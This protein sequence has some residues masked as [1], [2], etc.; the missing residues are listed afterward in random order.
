[1]GHQVYDREPH[2][3]LG[4]DTRILDSGLEIPPPL[5]EA[6]TL[7][8]SWSFLLFTIFGG[9]VPSYVKRWFGFQTPDVTEGTW[10]GELIQYDPR[11]FQT[12]L[13][14]LT[15]SKSR[16]DTVLKVCREKGGARFT[17]L[18]NQLIVHSL[19]GALAVHGSSQRSVDN[20]I[21][22][23][24]ID[25]RGLVVAYSDDM[26]VNCVS[27]AYEASSFHQGNTEKGL[28]NAA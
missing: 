13:S 18:L 20:L 2:Y 25:L 12:G 21:G 24:V 9:Y 5:E 26:M 15:V 14:M 23:I 6:C 11:N 7:R 10:T 27:A 19:S 1:M 16:M 3:D 28:R 4:C 17:G 8:V 22:Q